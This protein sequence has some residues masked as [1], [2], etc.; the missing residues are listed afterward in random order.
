MIARHIEVDHVEQRGLIQKRQ[1]ARMRRMGIRDVLRHRESLEVVVVVMQGQ[2]E[3]LEVV[4]ALSPPGGLARLLDRWQKQ[5]DQ[6]RDD[7]DHD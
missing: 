7:R 4:L 1:Q 5:C 6:D 2:P 3:L